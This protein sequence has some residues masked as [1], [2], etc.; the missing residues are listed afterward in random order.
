MNSDYQCAVCFQGLMLIW[1]LI[2]FMCL[3]FQDLS[4]SRSLITWFWSPS[5]GKL[6]QYVGMRSIVLRRASSYLCHT[7]LCRLKPLT[8]RL[9]L[10][11]LSL[12]LSP[13]FSSNK[14]IICYGLWFLCYVSLFLLWNIL[15]QVQE[16]V[17]RSG[18]YQR[19]LL[20]LHV[21]HNAKHASK[22][23]AIGWR[24]DAIWQYVCVERFSYE[25]HPTD[26]E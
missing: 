17:V 14:L 20:Q 13:F 12:S 9:N 5:A 22:R 18:S 16:A 11:W 6:D 26:F 21:L 25:W 4:S 3:F 19:L 15:R 10:G 1:A 7:H 23:Q 8:R 24:P 2:D